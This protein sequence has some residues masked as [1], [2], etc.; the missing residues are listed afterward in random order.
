MDWRSERLKRC[1]EGGSSHWSAIVAL[2]RGENIINLGQGSPDMPGDEATRQAAAAILSE[3]DNSLATQYNQYSPMQGAIELR[4]A[5]AD[6]NRTIYG[7]EYNSDNEVL[8]A[9]S[10]TEALYNIV[11]ALV[12][13]GEHVVVFEPFFPWYLPHLKMADAEVS[14]ITLEAPDFTIP[15]AEL[16]KVLTDRTKMLIFNT[17]HNPS[18]HVATQD[19]LSQL[20]QLCVK[21]NVLVV[22]DE[23]YENLV[24][25]P[26][27]H[28]RIADQPGMAQRTLRVGSASK[29]IALTGWRIGWVLA[30]EELLKPVK[31]YHAYTTFA[32]PTPL[33]LAVAKGIVNLTADSQLRQNEADLYSRNA[34]R[35]GEALQTHL[36]VTVFWPQGGYFLV[37]D[38]TNTK[39]VGMDFAKWLVEKHRIACVPMSVFYSPEHGKAHAHLVRF[40]ICKTEE[41][42]RQACL[43]L[44]GLTA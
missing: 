34:R 28:H 19:E 43:N 26:H 7:A 44:Q 6:F 32:A 20:A 1:G 27:C 11:M 40:A 10:G 33:Q 21:H 39:R 37:A 38:V 22:S 35:L 31:A 30:A 4:Q 23:V 41:T 17:P 36:G 24:F 12:N 9:T 3:R 42:I 16:E 25:A 29:L 14:I 5:I 15:F 2:A 13:P 18:G 8:I